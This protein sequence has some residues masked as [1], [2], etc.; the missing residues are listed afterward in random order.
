MPGLLSGVRVLD[1][2][3]VLSGPFAA[4]QLGLFGADV[5][6]IELPVVG[7]LAREIGDDDP[8]HTPMMSPSFMAQ[9]AGKRSLTLDLKSS[10]GAEIFERLVAGADVL[11]ENMRP[12]VLS[13]LGFGRPRLRELNR[14]LIY[15][16][17]TGFGQEGPLAR[18]PAYDQIIQGLAGMASVT[19]FPGD[20]PVRVGF[21]I[22]DTLGG[23]AGAMAVCA[24]LAGRDRTGEGAFLDVSMLDTAI[25]SMG[26]VVSN[27][28]IA[29]R[30]PGRIGN[31]N[32]TSAPS[33]TFRTGDGGLNIAANTQ[34]QFEALCGVLGCEELVTDP[35]FLT[36]GDRKRNRPA[37][38]LALEA[39]LS[40][41]GAREWEGL[42]SDVS[43]PAGR[44]LS[45]DEALSQ[46]QVASRGLLCEVEVEA[47]GRPVTV[48][49]S[50]VHV[51][52]ASLD[53]SSPPPRLGEHV[54]AILSDLGYTPDEIDALRA[55]HAV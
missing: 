35:R 29:G 23:Y 27:R 18:R 38:Q 26:W 28:L 8:A 51:D 22:A 37:L 5:I 20:D 39:A 44:V 52:G 30:D 47:V 2:T 21:P 48:L 25:T 41:R 6:K 55:A 40:T 16:A 46:E 45:V 19:G 34:A 14:R 17:I 42:L 11:V 50:A 15:C 10:G 32:T 43:V 13:R 24:A 54:D 33:G 31:D 12:G 4:Y 36:R 53:P 9:N 3:T 49:G 1:L 7:D